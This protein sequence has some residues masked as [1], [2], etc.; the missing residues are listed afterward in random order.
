M[1]MRP[2][3]LVGVVLIIAGVI[4]L[5]LRGISYTKDRHSTNVGPVQIST[6]QKGFVPPLAGI[7]AIVAGVALIAVGRQREA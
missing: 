1:D 2:A 7:V 5:S 4:V 6:V 3:G